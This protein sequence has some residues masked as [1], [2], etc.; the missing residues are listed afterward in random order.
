LTGLSR[1]Q[2]DKLLR[3][4][5]TTADGV[6]PVVSIS[7]G[8]FGSKETSRLTELAACKAVRRHFEAKGYAVESRERE[9]LGY[10]FEVTQ[11]NETLHVEVKGISGALLR[12][13]IT[14]NEVRCARADEKFRLAV[15]TEAIT[16][17][18]TIRV[19]SRKA[20]LDTFALSP[21]AYFAEARSESLA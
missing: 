14:A 18:R 20:F 7:G 13:P 5:R 6:A 2:A 19:F 1:Q 9:N 16:P 10:D 21:I 8:G 15:V 11:G 3:L 12:F 4:S 17:R